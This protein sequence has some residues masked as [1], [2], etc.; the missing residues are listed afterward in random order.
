MWKERRHSGHLELKQPVSIAAATGRSHD[1]TCWQWQL[2]P[3][4]IWIDQS[5]VGRLVPII[6]DIRWSLPIVVGAAT[7]MRNLAFVHSSSSPQVGK[8]R[9]G[10]AWT[11]RNNITLVSSSQP[12]VSL[13]LKARWQLNWSPRDGGRSDPLFKD[14]VC[15]HPAQP[16]VEKTMAHHASVSAFQSRKRLLKIWEANF[17]HYPYICTCIWYFYQNATL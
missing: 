4:Q 14:Q 13:I 11:N 5:E 2:L 1:S 6:G 8:H 15:V 7:T 9:I 12:T 3:K 10:F 16:H 17:I